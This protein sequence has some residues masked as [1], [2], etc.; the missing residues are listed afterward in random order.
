MVTRPCSTCSGEG[1]V[2]DKPCRECRGEG[3]RRGTRQLTIRIPPGIENGSRLRIA[4]EGDAGPSGGQAGDLY[5]VLTVAEDEMFEREGEDIVVRLDLPFPTLVLG[6]EV[7]VPTLDGEEKITISRGT[8]AGAEVRLHGRGFGRLARR[9]RG[10]FVVRIGVI[11]PE[12]PSQAETELLRRYA[13]LVGAPVA[14]RGVLSKAKKI[15]S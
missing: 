10:D 5:V 11:V 15:F 8:K 1:R 2:V 6:G 9:G 7:T 4:G 12:S 3:R 14:A 13:E